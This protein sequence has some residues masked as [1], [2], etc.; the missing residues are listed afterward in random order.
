MTKIQK[1]KIENLLTVLS[2]Y[3]R[4]IYREIFEYA[5]ELGYAPSMIKNAHG[6]FI[7]L[8]F[9]KSKL[10]KRLIKINLPGI[11]STEAEFMMQFY[12]A[13]EYSDFFHEK[14]RQDGKAAC[15]NQCEN[16]AGKYTYISANGGIAFRCAI[17]SLIK[18]SPFGAEHINEIKNLMRV[19]DELW[20][21]QRHIE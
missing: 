11:Y 16:C 13:T 15:K 19:Q 14:L 6:V 2:V 18:L 5:V 1:E 12:A 20:L 8:A 21:E 9:S 7:S 10:G 4:I 17:H 3:E